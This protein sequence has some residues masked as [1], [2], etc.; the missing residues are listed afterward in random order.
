MIKLSQY[1]VLTTAFLLAAFSA[2]AGVS[3]YD[4]LANTDK[5]VAAIIPGVDKP[6]EAMEEAVREAYSTRAMKG[7]S[8]MA[9]RKFD[10]ETTSNLMEI[11]A[12]PTPEAYEM[13]IL[14]DDNEKERQRAF[15]VNE[16]VEEN[17]RF[18]D[19]FD[20]AV[21][22]D[23]PAGIKKTIGNIKY[24]IIIE[25]M[26]MDVQQS[27]L[28]AYMVFEMPESGK[29]LAFG[30]RK[31]AFSN[32]GGLVSGARLEL[33]GD[34][35]TNMGAETLLIFKGGST[36]VE[37]DCN[38]FKSM[39][40][41]AE[42]EFSKNLFVPDSVNSST[43]DGRVKGRFTTVVSD[44]N[45]M[46]AEIHIDPFQVKGLNGFG[47]TI[48][49]AVFDHS[50]VQGIPGMS[51][52]SGYES[53]LTGPA[54]Q[55]IFI[56]NMNMRFPK[57]FNK[58]GQEKRIEVGIDKA[59]IDKHGISL[60]AEVR[61]VLAN[62]E[63]KMDKWDFSVDAF[64]LHLISNR[65]AGAGFEGMIELPIAKDKPFRYKAV[66]SS[67][68]NY[69]LAMSIPG[70]DNLKFDFLMGTDVEIYPSS[71]LEVK[72]KNGEFLPRAH[73]N[74]HLGI[75][76]KSL[77]V[78]KLQFQALEVQTVQPFVKIGGFG[79]GSGDDKNKVGAFAL[80]INNIHAATND[81]EM[82]LSFDAHVKL[83]GSKGGGFGGDAGLV[84]VSKLKD[85]GESQEWVHDR[86]DISKIGVRVNTGAVGIEGSLAWF[87]QD[88]I[89]GDGF[90]GEATMKLLKDKITVKAVALFGKQ[91]DLRYWFV[92]AL[93]TLDNGPT[94][95][96]MEL[97]A[98]GGGA[99]YHVKQSTEGPSNPLGQAISG[100]TY[101]PDENTYLRVLG[102]I[103][104]AM[105]KTSSVFNGNVSLE[106]EFNDG[107]GIRTVD[108]RGNGYFLSEMPK[109]DI[110][111]LSD[112]L[113]NTVKG[114]A[115]RLEPKAA[116]SAH[117]HI[118]YDVPAKT[119]HGNF[120]VFV[121]VAY[122]VIKGIGA[123]NRAGW[124]VI[125]ISPDDWY[126]HIGSPTDPVGLQLLGFVK[127]QSYF[128]V[129]DYIPASPAPPDNVSEI[130]GG[131]DLN[132]MDG[133]NALGEGK[134][135]AFGARF[136]MDTGNISFLMFYG[137]FA[138]GLG[139]DIMLKDYGGASCKGRNGPI[140]V[141]GWYAN[142]QAYAF[143]QG[144]IG[145]KVKLFG[146]KQRIPILEIGAAAILQAKLPNPFWM[147]GIVG[148]YFNVMNGLV[149]GNCKFEVTIGE[150]C[151]VV[152]GSVLE[153]IQVIS[154]V[155]PGDGESDIS[156]YTAAQGIF[157]MEVGKTFSMVDTDD[158]KKQ[159]RIKLD[160]FKLLDGTQ[161][162]AGTMEWN[163]TLDVVAFRPTDILPSEKALKLQLQISFEEKKGSAWVPVVVN[164]K[165]II[166]SKEVSFKT[167]KAPDHIQT[168]NVK[169]SYPVAGQ[170][171]FHKD[172]YDKGYIKLKQG[173]P[174]L[175]QP[176]EQW[177]Q[178][179]RFKTASGEARYFDFTYNKD[180]I[181]FTLPSGLKNDEIYTLEIVNLPA[182]AAQAIDRNVTDGDENVDDS[183]DITVKSKTASGSIEELQEK[184]I[185][186]AYVKTSKYNTFK[187]KLNAITIGNTWR[188]P[189]RP[190]VHELKA[191]VEGQEMFDTYEI[192]SQE[193]SRALVTFEAN[194][195]IPWYKN[196]IRPLAYPVDYPPYGLE[197][198]W[199]KPEL[200]GTPPTRALEIRQ[201]EEDLY[202]D[203]DMVVANVPVTTPQGATVIYNLPLA[204]Y[205]DYADLR[206]KAAIMASKGE[207]NSWMLRIMDTPYPGIN[208]G[209]TYKV[210][211]QYTLP[212]TNQVT[213]T[214]DINFTIN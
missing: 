10:F 100:L 121:N 50:S 163:E 167:D 199:R 74:G 54:W 196:E 43:G 64:Q 174:D 48:N 97:K 66:V 84:V 184:A 116:M 13:A 183:G 191:Y 75:E 134:G 198:E 130:L 24:T 39:G 40:I 34:H 125:H 61:N 76:A 38:G 12:F 210:I 53:A 124:A 139:F 49:K 129:G 110:G 162:L 154:Q 140:G 109:I 6:G 164:G 26:E 133:L 85:D 101:V 79:I 170:L 202:L 201:Q 99:F 70:K 25:S 31:I 92:D 197:Y 28:N 42:I 20:A 213:S 22:V 59:L 45:D 149:K 192:N 178:K 188:V 112:K 65:I 95:G 194:L 138:A 117:L 87:K 80:G 212:G 35:A 90:R 11:E 214:G 8:N 3:G 145:I 141:N 41:G 151:E 111:G 32:N 148:G 18:V 176:G 142:G 107:G 185:Y 81:N 103:D 72:V 132:Y 171:H 96:T 195:D 83:T 71:Y 208:S 17:K 106:I 206:Q 44:W 88:A 104:M 144:E 105:V 172:E 180:E 165:K 168:H 159:F 21:M 16:Y 127:A 187:A 62:G 143:F 52:P 118:N 78:K 114:V 177:I 60:V 47:F 108:L 1:I 55:G 93:A 204:S 9:V 157:N 136:G 181:N 94:I 37:W 67:G 150:E 102:R 126:L 5:P 153:S 155:T 58:K 135:I 190:T 69:A 128:M 113:K 68:D 63:G 182:K 46:I 33:L 73:L 186:T 14:S 200:Y 122:G 193:N 56:D 137:R 51:I 211:I 205:R 36:F 89:Y 119:L 57:Q 98:F 179:G 173:R 207:A 203:E 29:K 152:S 27:F 189:I 30:G 2:Q 23:L 77:K 156:V 4:S 131:V 158:R 169:Y 19:A 146:Q 7:Y 120:E 123:N 160:H 161:A 86:V 15:E 115:N 91:Q 175:F 166:E 147:R 82:R 209:T